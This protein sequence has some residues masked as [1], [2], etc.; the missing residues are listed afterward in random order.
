MKQ[1]WT[2]LFLWVSTAVS[3]A[4]PSPVRT[5]QYRPEG[6]D[7][8]FYRCELDLGGDVFWDVADG[9]GTDAERLY[10]VAPAGENALPQGRRMRAVI[11]ER[12]IQRGRDTVSQF[13]WMCSEYALKHGG[14]GPTLLGDMD[15]ERFTWQRA[16]LNRSP[17][18]G[19]SG[20]DVAPP[21]AFLI[22]DVQ[23][24]FSGPRSNR[25]QRADR[26]LLAVEL[27]PFIDDGKH[28]VTY[29]DH[30]AERIDIDPA[31]VKQYGLKIRPVM[32]SDAADTSGTKDKPH[33]LLAARK[34]GSTDALNISL[35]N[36]LS[37]DALSIQWET[38]GAPVS[39]AVT[40]DLLLARRSAWRPYAARSSGPVITSWVASGNSLGALRRDDQGR[41]GGESTSAFGIL[42][43]RA[44]V[45]ETLQMQE[46]GGGTSDDRERTIAITNLQGVTVQS[47]PYEELLAGKTGG[48]LALAE[49]VPKDQFLL[50]VARPAAIL[51]LL[52]DG[53]D[54]LSHLGSVMAGNSIKYDLNK[55]Y[56]SRL[57]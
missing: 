38:S 26:K 52:D 53:A 29:T 12:H 3:Q 45:R 24:A 22:P 49:V 9:S 41:R 33:I 20:I 44:A 34:V 30:S 39:S 16:Q 1:G 23:F 43:G 42:G 56:L 15:D 40:N 14:R 7:Y 19:F 8:D 32:S 10:L 36:S 51:P 28:W 11:L 2:V 57:T 54:F 25:V 17:W 35:T 18:E 21:Y 50:Y 37:A 48:H 13:G 31:L 4:A 46:L 55:H 47:H 6:S 27:T 5:E